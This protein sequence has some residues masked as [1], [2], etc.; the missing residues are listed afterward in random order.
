MTGQ[1]ISALLVKRRR[2]RSILV[3]VGEVDADATIVAADPLCQQALECQAEDMAIEDTLYALER[4]LT[5]GH[6]PAD[7]YLKQVIM[8]PQYASHIMHQCYQ[9][10]QQSVELSGIMGFA[11]FSAACTAA[12]RTTIACAYMD[13]VV[14]S[15][16]HV[17]ASMPGSFIAFACRLCF[18]LSI[19]PHHSPAVLHSL[20]EGIALPILSWLHTV[21]ICVMS[22]MRLESVCMLSLIFIQGIRFCAA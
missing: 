19:V 22:P 3:C 2:V 13:I 15:C 9:H 11:H 10:L 7:T 5:D 21:E 20:H 14:E 4:A 18:M 12:L 8:N 16:K 17:I 6:L 1:C